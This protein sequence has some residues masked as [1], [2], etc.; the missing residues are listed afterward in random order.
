MSY[1]IR[2]HFIEL[3]LR[4]GLISASPQVNINTMEVVYVTIG[5]PAFA[6]PYI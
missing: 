1:G 5:N 2:K 6:S 3:N 4:P